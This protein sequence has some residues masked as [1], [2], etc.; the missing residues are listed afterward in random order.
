MAAVVTTITHFGGSL[1]KRNTFKGMATAAGNG[2]TVK[3]ERSSPVE[4]TKSSSSGGQ[5]SSKVLVQADVLFREHHM[6]ME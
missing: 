5:G 4:K 3:K 6:L 1:S 2:A